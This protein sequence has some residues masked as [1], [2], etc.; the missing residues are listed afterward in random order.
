L[1]RKKVLVTKTFFWG[2]YDGN[3]GD[4]MWKTLHDHFEKLAREDDVRQ[5][6][7]AASERKAVKKRV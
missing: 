3:E 7:M 1:K 6:E 5:V 4:E 2:V